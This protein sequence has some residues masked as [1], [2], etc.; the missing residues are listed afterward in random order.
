MLR[1]LL[2]LEALELGPLMELAKTGMAR[3]SANVILV[4]RPGGTHACG[5]VYHPKSV[6]HWHGDHAGRS[7]VQGD[8]SVPWEV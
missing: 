8:G 4:G 1:R 3:G 5:S 6:T 2:L 7:L